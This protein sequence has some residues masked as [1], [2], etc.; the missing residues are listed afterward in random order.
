MAFGAVYG[1]KYKLFWGGV[2]VGVGVGG[3]GGGKRKLN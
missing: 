3:E 1:D 2:G